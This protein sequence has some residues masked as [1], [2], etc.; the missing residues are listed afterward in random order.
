[1][2]YPLIDFILLLISLFL[3]I[4]SFNVTYSAISYLSP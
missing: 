4:L 3:I 2:R 1:M